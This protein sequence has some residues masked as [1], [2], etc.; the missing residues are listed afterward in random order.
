MSSTPDLAGRAALSTKP[1]GREGRS[2]GAGSRLFA[3][4]AAHRVGQP[5]HPEILALGGCFVRSVLTAAVYRMIALPGA[6]VARGGI[7]RVQTGGAGV[8]VE[9]HLLPVGAADVL[10]GALPDPLAVG[11]VVLADGTPVDGIVC[12]RAPAGAL[13]ITEHISWPGYLLA[14]APAG[15]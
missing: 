8:E 4:V 9:L 10:A 15:E 5:L 2:A 11:E 7:V 12:T 6:G 3:V 1:V 13:D 14:T